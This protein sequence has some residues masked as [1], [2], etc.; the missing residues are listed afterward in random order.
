MAETSG[1]SDV[2]KTSVVSGAVE[3][4][5]IGA[6]GRAPDLHAAEV[7]ARQFLHAL[8]I[9]TEDESLRNTPA[10]MTKAGCPFTAGISL[11]RPLL[12]DFRPG[13]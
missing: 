1:L 13:F 3:T 9:S 2:V 4:S 5:G 7:A 10:R 12:T 8:G 6:V 11:H